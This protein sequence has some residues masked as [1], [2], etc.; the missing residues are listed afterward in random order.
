MIEKLK[1]LYPAINEQV[2]SL[3]LDN[4]EAFVCD[5]C[6]VDALTPALESIVFKL[7]QEDVSKLSAEGLSSESTGGNS[8]SYQ[9]DYSPSIYTRLNRHK[10]I[11]VVG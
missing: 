3:L 4:A 8:V 1:M 9:E 7:V 11:K 2:L 10:R 5:Y 6:N